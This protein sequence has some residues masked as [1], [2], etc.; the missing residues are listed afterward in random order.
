MRTVQTHGSWNNVRAEDSVCFLAAL[1]IM[2]VPVKWLFASVMAAMVH[3][4]GHICAVRLCGGEI[5]NV[6]I[7]LGSV[8]MHSAPMRPWCSIACIAAGPVMSFALVPLIRFAPRV[9]ICGLVQGLYNLLPIMPLDGGRLLRE[10]TGLL[11]KP[12]TASIICKAVEMVTLIA[13]AAGILIC[14]AGAIALA[15]YLGFLY[16]SI[17]R[18]CKESKMRVQ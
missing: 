12:K 15:L 17:K 7:R 4:L 6:E 16:S 18:P 1:L 5:R 11:W 13:L 3:E 2:T 9:A 8:C 10:L 14:K